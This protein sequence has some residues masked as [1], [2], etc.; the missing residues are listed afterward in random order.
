MRDSSLA[1]YYF[2]GFGMNTTLRDLARMGLLLA[3]KGAW[4]GWRRI[5]LA[6]VNAMSESSSANQDYGMGVWLDRS[7]CGAPD[8]ISA[9][10][11]GG[12][13]VAIHPSLD[14]VLVGRDVAS[15]NFVGLWSA[16]RPAFN[17]FS[18]SDCAGYRSGTHRPFIVEEDE[19]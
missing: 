18:E 13:I 4:D 6:Y 16:V 10:G 17:D 1:D 15:G 5:P 12:Q 14:V 9:V 19:S 8:V 2:G 11:L 3:H 7:S